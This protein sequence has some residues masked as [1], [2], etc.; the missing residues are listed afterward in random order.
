MCRHPEYGTALTNGWLAAFSQAWEAYITGT[1]PIGAAV[2][3][4][5]GRLVASSRNRIKDTTAPPGEIFSTRLAHAELNALLQTER[6]VAGDLRGLRLLATCEPC[7]LCLGAI[8]MSS[9]RKITYAV[10]DHRASRRIIMNGVRFW[11]QVGI[12]HCGCMQP[13][14]TETRKPDPKDTG[15]FRYPLIT[16]TIM[17]TVIAG[18]AMTLYVILFR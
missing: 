8:V 10:R 9:I 12:R 5:S 7:P 16:T 14:E 3:D 17:I 2:V 4:P 13:E 18:Y 6:T 1:Y 11:G 15:L